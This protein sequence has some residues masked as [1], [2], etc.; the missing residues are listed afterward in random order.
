MAVAARGK[1]LEGYVAALGGEAGRGGTPTL[2]DFDDMGPGD[3][4][5][6]DIPVADVTGGWAVDLDA[7]ERQS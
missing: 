7:D 2:D 1:D 4:G 6:D 5:L 3:L